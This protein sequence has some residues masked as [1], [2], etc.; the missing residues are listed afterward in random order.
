[1]L[2]Y[3]YGGFPSDDPNSIQKKLA[4]NESTTKRLLFSKSLRNLSVPEQIAT[5]ETFSFIVKHNPTLLP[6]SENLVLVFF[7]ELLKMMSVADGEMTS[8]SMA[9]AVIINKDGYNP[10]TE[11]RRNSCMIS[12]HSSLSHA[13]GIFLREEYEFIVDGIGCIVV[14]TDP[15]MGIQFRVSSLILFHSV[16]RAHSDTFFDADPSSSI[17]KHVDF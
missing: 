7:S 16:L 11:A 10:N 6:V 9:N 5:V 13:S 3:L 2:K 12:P 8:E 1:M 17:G 4:D 15:P 14:P